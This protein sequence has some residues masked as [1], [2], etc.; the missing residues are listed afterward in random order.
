MR[1]FILSILILLNIA[2]LSAQDIRV[3]SWLDTSRIYIGDQ[4]YFN[5]EVEQPSDKELRFP[6]YKDT[7]RSGIENLDFSGPDTLVKDSKTSIINLKYLITCFDTGFYEIEPV[8]VERSD[9]RGVKR[10]YSD[11]T[12][13]EVIR[14]DIAPK[15]STDVIFDIVGPR[16]ARLNAMEVIPWLLLGIVLIIITYFLV[17]Y[18]RKSKLVEV[19]EISKLPSE[20]FHIIALRDIDK[21]EKEELWQNSRHK[22]YYSKLTEILRT[23]IDRQYAISCMEMTSNEILTK[24]LTVGFT[25]DPLY[26][27]LESVLQIADLSKFAKFKAREEDNINAMD[28][29]RLFVKGTS[30]HFNQPEENQKTE[31]SEE[32]SDE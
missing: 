26:Y 8:F 3:N 16:R 1:R 12:H 14:V 19:D 18:F 23:Y 10:E 32:D 27:K 15:D 11:Y 29:A 6:Y 24:L 28:N 4:I 13:L 21:L 9:E 30:Q 20:P 2:L 17:R 5:I 25:S 22:L 7:L 31:Q